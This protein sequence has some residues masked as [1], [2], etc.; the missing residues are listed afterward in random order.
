[1][2]IESMVARRALGTAF[3]ICIAVIVDRYASTLQTGWV[4]LVAM[5][6]MQLTIRVNLRLVLER[7]LTVCFAIFFISMLLSWLQPVYQT[8]FIVLL[9]CMMCSVHG[10]FVTK[11]RLFSVWLMVA[12]VALILLVPSLSSQHL[13]ERMH[14]VVLGGIVGILSSMI[15]CPGRPEVDFRRGVI[16]V[17][18]AYSD[19]LVAISALLFRVSHADEVVQQKKIVV[20][21]VLQEQRAFFPAWVYE[22]GFNPELQ[23]GHRHFL[24]RVEQMGQVLFAMHQVARHPIDLALLSEFQQGLQQAV[25]QLQGML[26]LFVARLE[27]QKIAQP[28][29]DFG[30]DLLL[31]E[32]TYRQVIR[33]P[34]EALDLSQDYI[35]IAAFIYDLKDLYRLTVK[36]AEALR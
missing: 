10:L 19:Y 27:L 11:D 28:L 17:L 1:M 6:I 30:K 22:F 8:I 13:Y 9:F 20:E 14:D 5:M 15:I 31:L 16:P 21:R 24:I 3:A 25:E 18:H 35:D 2:T 34:L 12:A 7:T 33:V 23:Q 36:L 32:E 26:A 29:E 4:P